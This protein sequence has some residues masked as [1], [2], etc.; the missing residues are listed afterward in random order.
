[1]AALGR[2]IV[3][4]VE[5][6]GMHNV[7][8]YTHA[9]LRRFMFGLKVCGKVILNFGMHVDVSS[10]SAGVR[11]VSLNVSSASDQ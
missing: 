8:A 5:V 11:S 7:V 9:L 2:Q 1:M 3:A 10:A 6:A 4:V